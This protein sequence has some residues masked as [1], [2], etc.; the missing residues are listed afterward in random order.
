MTST[1]GTSARYD[2][3]GVRRQNCNLRKLPTDIGVGTNGIIL[4]Y[5][6]S[7]RFCRK[8]LAVLAMLAKMLAM[9]AMLQMLAKMLAMLATFYWGG[10]TTSPRH[11]IPM[12]SIEGPLSKFSKMLA[13]CWQCWQ[14]R[15]CWQC[16]QK[17]WQC[18]QCWRKCWHFFRKT[19]RN[20]ER[21]LGILHAHVR[22]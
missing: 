19:P 14:C 7:S 6:G 9:M 8:M 3:T 12:V 20:S 10:A 2:Q 17:C 13:K 15:K 11:D 5:V 21:F 1:P 18:W 16:W 4:N 22:E